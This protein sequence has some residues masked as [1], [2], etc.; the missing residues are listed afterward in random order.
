MR[1]IALALAM[2]LA[3]GCSSSNDGGGSSKGCAKPPHRS[4]GPQP[5]GAVFCSYPAGGADQTIIKCHN[6][7][8][9]QVLD[10]A[11]STVTTAGG[12]VHSCHCYDGAVGDGASCGY[13]YN[14]QCGITV[15]AR[16]NGTGGGSGSG[17]STPGSGGSSGA[18]SG[19]SSGAGS[20]GSSGA[21]SGGSSACTTPGDF[22]CGTSPAGVETP[23]PAP[24]ICCYTPGPVQGDN[25]GAIS[26]CV[27]PGTAQNVWDQCPSRQYQLCKTDAECGSGFHCTGA[28][29]YYCQ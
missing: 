10:C 18:G 13:T 17:G 29:T 7:E 8:W 25:C 26:R 5:E 21:G 24:Q 3:A 14:N 19:G 12:F 23:C 9:E 27:A 20:G 2:A 28:P 22:Q 16:E 1:I 11:D 6:G 4:V 15:T